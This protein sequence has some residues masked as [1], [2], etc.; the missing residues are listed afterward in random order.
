[1]PGRSARPGI[2]EKYNNKESPDEK[3]IAHNHCF[4][5]VFSR[6]V[7]AAVSPRIQSME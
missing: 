3:K 6:F 5:S 7:L 2:L 4:P 1:M